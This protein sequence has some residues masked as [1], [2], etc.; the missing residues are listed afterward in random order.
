MTSNSGN[1][2]RGIV[3]MRGCRGGM[4]GWGVR[5]IVGKGVWDGF[6]GVRGMKC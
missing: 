3:R 4:G 2:G 5:N 6:R 1:K